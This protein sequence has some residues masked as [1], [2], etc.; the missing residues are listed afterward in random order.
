MSM[1]L[2]LEVAVVA[3]DE[4]SFVLIR[5]IPAISKTGIAPRYRL[6]AL[7]RPKVRDVTPFD[8]LAERS[9]GYW[10]ALDD[11]A[12]AKCKEVFAKLASNPS[13][14]RGFYDSHLPIAVV[15][16]KTREEFGE[17]TEKVFEAFCATS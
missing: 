14:S 7:H 16:V 11:N 10:V 13:Y 2:Y 15:L 9:I 8:D 3:T 4:S 6:A 17:I 5:G 1:P 12:F